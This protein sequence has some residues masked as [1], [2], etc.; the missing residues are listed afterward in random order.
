MNLRTEQMEQPEPVSLRDMDPHRRNSGNN[1]RKASRNNPHCSDAV[2]VVIRSRCGRIL[3]NLRLIIRSA[4]QAVSKEI[5][6]I[7]Q[8][9]CFEQSRED[10][11]VVAR[12]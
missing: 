10:L 8:T 12:A 3:Y 9:V 7:R 4:S 6:G 5:V 1:R 11:A 2:V